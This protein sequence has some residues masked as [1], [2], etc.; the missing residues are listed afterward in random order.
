MASLVEAGADVSSGTYTC[1]SCG[2]KLHV[3]LTD[4]LRS[5][6]SCGSGTYYTASGGDAEDEPEPP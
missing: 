3:A 5:C 2:Y 4:R 1:T 6:P